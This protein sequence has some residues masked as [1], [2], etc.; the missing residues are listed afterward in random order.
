M[1]IKP[2]T[3]K[4]IKDISDIAYELSDDLDLSCNDVIDIAIDLLYLTVLS[5][6]DGNDDAIAKRTEKIKES[7]TG[8]IGDADKTAA[9]I[10][11][12]LKNISAAGG[13]DNGN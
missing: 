12:E 1:D 8:F 4:K 3:A 10:K 5:T 6:F 2:G 9:F 11:L 13:V 7:L